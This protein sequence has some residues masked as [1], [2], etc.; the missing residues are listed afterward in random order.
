[1]TTAETAERPTAA[2]VAKNDYDMF[3]ESFFVVLWF[4]LMHVLV[5]FY[6]LFFIF[7]ENDW[8]LFFSHVALFHSGI[9]QLSFWL[10]T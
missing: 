9:F 1:M 2:E 8:K 5:V 6:F 4:N 10:N 3:H 7:K